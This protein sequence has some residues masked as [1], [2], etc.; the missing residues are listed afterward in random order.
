MKTN[1]NKTLEEVL[2]YKTELKMYV[3]EKTGNEYQTEVIPV[4]KVVSIG[5]VESIGEEYI[6]SIV[7]VNHDLEY[8]IKTSNY[9]EVKFG[10]MLQFKNVRGGAT[11][12]GVGWYKADN[13]TVIRRDEKI[14]KNNQE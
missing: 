7:D 9:V 5:S 10:T 2:K 6:Y 12:N 13:V 1:W 11:S 14:S 4:L 8:S 3:S